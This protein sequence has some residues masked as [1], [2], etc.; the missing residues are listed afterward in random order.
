MPKLPWIDFAIA[1]PGAWAVVGQMGDA[2]GVPVRDAMIV[3]AKLAGRLADGDFSVGVT[4][5]SGWTTVVCAL[6]DPLAAQRLADAVGARPSQASPEGRHYMFDLDDEALAQLRPMVQR[7]SPTHRRH[8]RP[9]KVM[10]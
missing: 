2:T 9:R 3:L 6:A 8:G 7:P 5:D 10:S 4:R 1:Y